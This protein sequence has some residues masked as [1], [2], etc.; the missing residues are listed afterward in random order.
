[1]KLPR[2]RPGSGQQLGCSD[3]GGINRTP[4]ARLGLWHDA[5]NLSSDGSPTLCVRKARVAAESLEGNTPEAPIVA[6]VTLVRRQR[7]KALSPMTVTLDGM[8]YVP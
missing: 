2:I 7:E 5:R 6:M 3:F 4:G 1:M 8:V